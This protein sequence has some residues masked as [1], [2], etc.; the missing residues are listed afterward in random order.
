[1]AKVPTVPGAPVK[2]TDAQI[3][4]AI[5]AVA[6]WAHVG[7]VI[8]R[9]FAFD[10]FITAMAFVNRVAQEAEAAQH[11]PDILIRYNKVTLSVNT[12]D[13]GG[14][15]KKDFDLALKIDSMVTR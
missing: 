4:K 6:D 1:M 7:D 14:I 3:E 10:N 15:T 12:H 2:L 11:H 13:A 9:T 8:Q 5:K